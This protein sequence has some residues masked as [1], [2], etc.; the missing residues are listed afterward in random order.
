MRRSAQNNLCSIGY[1]VTSTPPK[2]LL[3][4]AEWLA[5]SSEGTA[6]MRSAAA[7]GRR[8]RAP[9]GSSQ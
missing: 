9:P 2:L 8:H 4:L 7:A 1:G 3:V 6:S 5:H